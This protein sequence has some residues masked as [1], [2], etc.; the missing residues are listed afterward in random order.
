VGL[1]VAASLLAKREHAVAS[2]RDIGAPRPAIETTTS[3]GTTT[4]MP[5][6]MP[7]MMINNLLLLH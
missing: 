3:A 4:R 5:T 6:T 1:S 7:T 2:R